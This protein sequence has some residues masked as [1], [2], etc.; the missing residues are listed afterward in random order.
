LL[1]SPNDELRDTGRDP[2]P[3]GRRESLIGLI[4][5]SRILMQRLKIHSVAGILAL[6]PPF[7][8]VKK[9]LRLGERGRGV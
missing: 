8:K 2:A 6:G 4:E 5:I 3:A 7:F 1:L 9:G